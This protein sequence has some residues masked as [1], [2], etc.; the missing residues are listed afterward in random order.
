LPDP[1]DRIRAEPKAVRAKA[2]PAA[3]RSRRF[4]PP[5]RRVVAG[6]ALAA[7][8]IGI[9]VNAVALQHGRRLDLRPDPAAAAVPAPAPTKVAA[10]APAQAPHVARAPPVTAVAPTPP[11]KS[12]DAIAEFLRT[13]NSDKRG[14]TRSAQKALAKLGFAVKPTGA[15]DSATRSAL[16]EFAKSRRLPASTEIT[17]KLVKSL[18][19]A[20]KAE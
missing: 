13:Q 11:T 10:V 2:A 5:S 7:M 18:T 4:A 16:A 6:A 15:L 8:M 19:A 3:G 1:G 12:G 20:A 9:V 14:L 17:A